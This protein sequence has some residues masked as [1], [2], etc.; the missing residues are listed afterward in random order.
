MKLALWGDSQMRRMYAYLRT[1]GNYDIQIKGG[2]TKSGITISQ[3]K[4]MIK[5]QRPQMKADVTYLISIGTNDV[6]NGRDFYHIKRDFLSLLATIK[7][8]NT[9]SAEVI[10][11]SIPPF[12]R[13]SNNS[14]VLNIIKQF[15]TLLASTRTEQVHYI[16]WNFTQRAELYFEDAY[17]NGRVDKIHL[18][19]T[20]F[21]YLIQA[22]LAKG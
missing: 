19:S 11:V 15:N 8:M 3:L 2:L 18:N 22:V 12:P 4:R 16:E 13:Y 20:G 6:K 10:V 1:S 21:R 7:K 9:N 5:E 14:K 17:N